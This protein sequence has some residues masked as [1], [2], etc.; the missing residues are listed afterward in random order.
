MTAEIAAKAMRRGLAAQLLVV[1][2]V[3]HST[4]HLR[5]AIAEHPHYAEVPVE[6]RGEA[7]IFGDVLRL[8]GVEAHRILLETESTNCGDNALRARELLEK[9]ELRPQ[10]IILIQDPTM[11]RRTHASFLQAWRDQPQV[12]FLNYSPFVPRVAAEG[13]KLALIEQPWQQWSLDRYLSL[14]MGEIPRLDDSETGYGPRGR[15]FIPH[16]EIPDRVRAA[17]RRLMD[18]KGLS[19]RVALP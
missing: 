12:R 5:W 18:A 9:L 16:V 3:G 15:G 14:V 2:G 19:T 1:G 11:Q 13:G 10:S 7:E 6:G 4:H 17:H 8:R